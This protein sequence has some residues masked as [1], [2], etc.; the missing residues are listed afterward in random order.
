MLNI[1]VLI[2]DNNLFNA[3]DIKKFPIIIIFLL[4]F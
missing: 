2:I 1:S 3:V 4:T